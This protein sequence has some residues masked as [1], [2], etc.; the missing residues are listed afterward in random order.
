M[1]FRSV[2]IYML[3]A[4]F[5]AGVFVQAQGGLEIRAASSTEV[6][7]WGEVTLPRGDLVWVSPANALTSADI[8]RAE[9]HTQSNGQPTVRFVFTGEGARK[10]SQ[11]TTAQLG[12][13]VVLL[14]GGTVVWAPIVRSVMSEEAELSGLTPDVAARVLASIKPQR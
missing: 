7:G 12:K 4:V 6:A 14:L 9:A 11:L 13:P 8:A 1:K 10:M 3:L 2:V 5:F